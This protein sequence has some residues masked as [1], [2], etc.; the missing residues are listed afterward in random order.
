MIKE[1]PFVE[2]ND[3]YIKEE[4]KP[5]TIGGVKQNY[6]EVSNYGSVRNIKGQYINPN[7]INSGYL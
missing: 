6:Y 2:F 5:I 4:W 1:Y 7:Y 3:S